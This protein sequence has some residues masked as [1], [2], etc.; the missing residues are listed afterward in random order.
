MG[1]TTP[2]AVFH[3]YGPASHDAD[4]QYT[5][6]STD[7]TSAA[8]GTGGGIAFAGFYNG[9]INKAG[10]A[11]IRGVKENGIQGDYASTLIFDTRVNGGNQ[12][13]RMRITSAGNVG[14][15]TS[16]PAAKLE[17]NGT[18]QFDG[19]VTFASGQNVTGNFNV[20]APASGATGISVQTTDASAGNTA[21][22][23]MADGIDGSGV[24]GEAENG[25][26][27]TGVWGISSS[28][29]AGLFSGDI[30]VTGA[31]TAGTKD[32]KIDDPIDPANKFLYHASVESSQMKTI[33]DGATTLDSRGEAE[34]QLP[35]WFDAL[36][37]EF[38]YQLTCVGGYAPVYIAQK[39]QGNSFKIAGGKPGLEVDWQVTGVRHDAYAQAH[40]LTVEVEKA[41]HERGF[42]L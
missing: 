11:N 30:N 27:A 20:I 31:I 28:G 35:A 39:I 37:G 16:T 23:G 14:I 2:Q 17:V 38:R 3:M 10:F 1:T 32:F 22:S 8:Q 36:N 13:E 29:L 6:I 5:M 40:P 26:A 24:V 7:T 42:Y 19:A 25:A 15:G 21:I 34:V 33:Y 41:A 12:T 9:T 4:A 18:A